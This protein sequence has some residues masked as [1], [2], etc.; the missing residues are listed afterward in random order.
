MWDPGSNPEIKKKKKGGG[1]REICIKSSFVP[2]LVSQVLITEAWL[3]KGM[4]DIHELSTL[5]FS[6]S[7]SL[8]IISEH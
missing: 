2:M 3:G 1:T 4:K 7:V 8:N 5:F 6:F